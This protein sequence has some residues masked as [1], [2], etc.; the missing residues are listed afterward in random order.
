[1]NSQDFYTATG[2]TSAMVAVNATVTWD[3]N[4]GGV[5][6]DVIFTTPAAALAVGNGSQGNIPQHTQGMNQ[7]RFAA[8]GSYPFHCDIHTGMNGTVEVQ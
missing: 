3:N 7:R 4:S 6:H 5:Q 2:T 8:P 1:M